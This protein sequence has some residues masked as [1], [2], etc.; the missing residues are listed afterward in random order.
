MHM[1]LRLVLLL[2]LMPLL[3]LL[4]LLLNYQRRPLEISFA[5][6]LWISWTVK[7]SLPPP[8]DSTHCS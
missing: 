2:M 6:Y 3:L 8:F 4:L 5:R 1:R 7:P